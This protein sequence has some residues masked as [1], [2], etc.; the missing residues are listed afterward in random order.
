MVETVLSIIYLPPKVAT[1]AYSKGKGVKYFSRYSLHNFGLFYTIWTFKGLSAVN[2]R[3]LFAST[4]CVHY[5][6]TNRWILCH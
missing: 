4:L 3:T 6:I 2:I 1:S 5:S